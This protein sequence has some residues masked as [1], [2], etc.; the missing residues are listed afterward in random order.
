MNIV[1]AS[2]GRFELRA[3]IKLREKE[4]A[5]KI[6]MRPGQFNGEDVII[7]AKRSA[8]DGMTPM[9]GRKERFAETQ[10]NANVLKN[11]GKIYY[12]CKLC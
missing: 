6:T 2:G 10:V 3:V 7:T 1:V 11:S 8:A 4:I 5:E 9:D 12:N